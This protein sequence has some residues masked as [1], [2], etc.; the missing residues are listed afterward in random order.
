MK[1][2]LIIFINF[3]L[4]YGKTGLKEVG[5]VLRGPVQTILKKVWSELSPDSMNNQIKDIS[6]DLSEIKT[7]LDKIEQ[8]V[9]FGQDVKKIEYLIET[10]ERVISQGKSA[11]ENWANTALEYGSDGFYFTLNSLKKLMDG[12]SKLFAD[13]GSIFDTIAK[14]YLMYLLNKL[15]S[16]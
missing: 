9:I 5:K 14:R 15:Q 12:S 2:W 8:A 3:H 16:L 4:G 11:S 6:R 1:I 7:H 13:G 10:Y